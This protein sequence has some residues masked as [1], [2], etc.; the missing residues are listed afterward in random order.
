MESAEIVRKNYY[1]I[2]LFFMVG[3]LVLGGLDFLLWY[4][5]RNSFFVD[6]GLKIIGYGC[7]SVVVGL[8]FLFLD[9]KI[10]LEGGWSRRLVLRR[11]ILPVSFLF[12][13]FIAA[14][15]LL[16]L[17]GYVMSFST[18]IIHNRSSSSIGPVILQGPGSQGRVETILPRESARLD[19]RFPG[20]GG[21]WFQ[22]TQNQKEIRGDFGYVCS[23]IGE[24]WTITIMENG[25]FEVQPFKK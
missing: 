4:L 22:A 20:E 23:S 21:L 2:S 25:R 18:I 24:G 11:G 12:F 15:G 19:I 10:H 3:P 8:V 13:D 5:T 6:A 17:A 9:L 1:R 7:I 14:G 16:F